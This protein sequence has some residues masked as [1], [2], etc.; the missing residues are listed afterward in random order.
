MITRRDVFAGFAALPFTAEAFAAP[1]PPEGQNVL[2]PTVFAWDD[3]KPVKNEHGEVR[4]LCKSP[5]ATGDQLELPSIRVSPPTPPTATSMRSSSS[6]AKATSK[7]SPMASGLRLSLAQ[8]SSMLPTA[9]TACATS[10]PPRR[11][12][13]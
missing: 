10:V 2:G 6:S 11:L 13:T 5:T 9:C 7:P 4:S 8:L 12:T 3:M 1:A